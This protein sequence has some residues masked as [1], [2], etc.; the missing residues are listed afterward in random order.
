MGTKISL[1]DRSK[2]YSSNLMLFHTGPMQKPENEKEV[3]YSIRL[4]RL[5]QSIIGDAQ[6]GLPYG[7]ASRLI[8]LWIDTEIIYS[9]Y[10][11]GGIEK[12]YSNIRGEKVVAGFKLTIPKSL[13]DFLTKKLGLSS[14]SIDAAELKK[15]L[16]SIANIKYRTNFVNDQGDMEEE[17]LPLIGS[18]RFVWNGTD[19]KESHLMIEP[20]YYK[21]I[22]EKR[23][24][25]TLDMEIIRGFIRTPEG[26]DVYLFC[27][28]TCCTIRAESI[29]IPLGELQVQLNDNKTSDNFKK[30]VQRI[31]ER[32]NKDP[33]VNVEVQGQRGRGKQSLLVLYSTRNR[34]PK[35][36]EEGEDIV[37]LPDRSRAWLTDQ[38]ERR[39]E[40]LAY[41]QSKAEQSSTEKKE[42]K[43]IVKEIEGIE[44]K[45]KAF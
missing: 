7:L 25:L 39:K 10:N 38:L 32:I 13:D 20:K 31:V 29:T 26:I 37:E 43:L 44:K 1:I 18:S 33:L 3:V 35:E 30:M 28:H 14:G 16:E 19:L 15:Q 21:Y 27:K 2:S 45:L 8:K 34:I 24:W 5:T 6:K 11:K 40:R 17:T 23:R 22:V 41:L 12:E 36:D 9:S 4:G 42:I